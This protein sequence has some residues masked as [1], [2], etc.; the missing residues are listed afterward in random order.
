MGFLVD[1][2][3]VMAGEGGKG[4]GKGGG[5]RRTKGKAAP[6][7][8]TYRLSIESWTENRHEH[9]E[10]DGGG[11]GAITSF[12]TLRSAGLEAQTVTRA[13]PARKTKQEVD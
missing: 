7:E 12:G 10:E 5:R 4:S 13:K 8:E 3:E 1:V 2:L 9:D 11:L 6:D